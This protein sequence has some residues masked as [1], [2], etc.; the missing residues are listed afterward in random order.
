[1]DLS[2]LMGAAPASNTPT[3]LDGLGTPGEQGQAA[4]KFYSPESPLF[5]FGL[6]LAVTTGL[7]AFG[8]SVRVGGTSASLNI[9]NPK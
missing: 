3:S 4:A 9:G 8:T 6:L 5:A 7:M 1:M 2:P